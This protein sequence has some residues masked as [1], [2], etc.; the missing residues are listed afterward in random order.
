MLDIMQSD[1][2][3]EVIPYI[4]NKFTETWITGFNY[5]QR[6]PVRITETEQLNPDLISD[7]KFHSALYYTA[8]LFDATLYDAPMYFS[9]EN[10]W[11]I[12][13]VNYWE[14][15]GGLCIYLSALL[16]MLLLDSKLLTEKDMSFCQGYYFH[17]L[18]DDFPEFMRLW[19]NHY[20]LH[21]W[22]MI[23][24]SV[25]DVS[26]RQEF[27]TFDFK[28][29]DIVVGKLPEGMDFYGYRE[30]SRTPKKYARLFASTVG[31]KHE[32][33]LLK[34]RKACLELY[35]KSLKES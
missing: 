8:L 2:P 35:L 4:Q 14:N 9:D 3:D 16:Y 13:E 34:H 23:G 17:K 1:N 15:K 29:K 26:I 5:K 12:D 20:G 21:S 18:R 22:L 10:K 31:M 33:W 25:V 11:I 19:E 6:E 32:L 30:V 28:G 27:Q 7:Y 24:N